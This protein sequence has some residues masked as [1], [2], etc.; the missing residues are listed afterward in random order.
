M[1]DGNVDGDGRVGL[2]RDVG[3]G[4]LYAVLPEPY[5]HLADLAKPSKW[6]AFTRFFGQKQTFGR[7]N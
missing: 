1:S 7:P 4:Y 6:S 2:D 3:H 5:L